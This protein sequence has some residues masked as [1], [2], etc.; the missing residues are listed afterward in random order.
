MELRYDDSDNA[1]KYVPT[2]LNT[3]HWGPNVYPGV[4]KVRMG[5]NSFMDKQN[6]GDRMILR[7]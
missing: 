1:K 2:Q 5:E 7:G 4:K 6:Y 3:G